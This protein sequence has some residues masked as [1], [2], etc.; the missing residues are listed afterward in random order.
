MD[1][2]QRPVSAALRRFGK[3]NGVEPETRFTPL[4]AVYADKKRFA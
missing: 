1:G 2:P 3:K 4:F